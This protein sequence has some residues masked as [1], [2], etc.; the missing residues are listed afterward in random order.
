VDSSRFREVVRSLLTIGLMALAVL[1]SQDVGATPRYAVRVGQNCNLCHVNPGG[2]GMR[3]LYASQY[4]LPT[5][6][7][8]ETTPESD[9]GAVNPQIGDNVVIGADL[10]TF[11]MRRNDRNVRTNF[12]QMQGSVYL[13]FLL[14]PRF[15]AYVHED[16]G[17]GSATTFE[18]YG[19]GYFFGGKGFVRAGKFVPSFGW[20]V[21][22]HRSFTRREFV[23]LPSFPP[24]ADTGV[25]VGV[26]PGSFTLTAS[27]TDGEYRAAFDSNENFAWTTRGSYRYT[28]EFA[29]TEVGG[30]FY[31]N[32]NT[33][34]K[35]QAGGPFAA[36]SCWRVTWTGE[37]DWTRR[38]LRQPATSVIRSITTVH[39]LAVEIVQGLDLVAT[40][41]FYDPTFDLKSGSAHRIGGGVD[42]LVY[43]FLS[44][45]GRVNHFR[46]DEGPDIVAAF[47]D[48]YTEVQVQVHFLY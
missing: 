33:V 2:G 18:I 34:E 37:F 28:S 46:V 7:A 45:Q 6:L 20:K 1:L 11:F 16:L 41:D 15:S 27:L 38:E 26:Y 29:N 24:H 13:S 8:M 4:L 47:P 40:Y 25:E 44:V 43:P 12:V 21:P 31:Q 39:E 36:A 23:F 19:L 14:S 17:Q 35:R 9:L 48:E 5:R 42:A 10:R 3:D 30:S 32:A 22:D